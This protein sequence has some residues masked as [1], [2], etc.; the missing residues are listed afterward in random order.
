VMPYPVTAFVEFR[1]GRWLVT[2]LGDD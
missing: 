2:D 1:A